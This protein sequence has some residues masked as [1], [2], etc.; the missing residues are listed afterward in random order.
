[1][2]PVLP[3]YDVTD[4]QPFFSIVMP[5]Y[6]GMP[7]LPASIESI[8]AQ[9]FTSWELI[10]A[11]D[12]S[13]DDSAEAVKRLQAEHPQA[14]IFYHRKPEKF[15]NSPARVRNFGLSKVGGRW[16]TFLDQDDL[17][18][19]DRLQMHF[20][21]ISKNP[22][23]RIVHNDEIFIDSEGRK[24]SQVGRIVGN[25]ALGAER[26]SGFCFETEFQGN[27]F[28]L[29]C[30]SLRRDVLEEV[31]VFNEE[32]FGTEDYDLFLRVTARYP[33][34]FVN[35]PL[36]N[37]RKHGNNMSGDGVLMTENVIR[38]LTNICATDLP[39]V[40]RIA[41]LKADRFYF[42]HRVLADKLAEKGERR[43][44][45]WQMAQALKYKPRS[46]GTWARLISL[47]F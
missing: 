45:W 46:L 36:T 34:H 8:I 30:V 17:W 9:T 3:D 41:P 29:S 21:M 22:D 40:R 42:L 6:K 7:Y 47:L 10:V 33:V 44:A 1:L 35:K 19:P 14:A 25:P 39:E 24:L 5:V 11:D 27:F 12:Q 23:A 20:E 28:G 37:W 32:V 26:V 18:E 13:P 43:K 15:G 2:S 4:T 31:G 38:S 16:V